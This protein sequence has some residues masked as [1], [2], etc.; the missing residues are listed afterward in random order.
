MEAGDRR[1][2]ESG[3]R[4]DG[5]GSPLATPSETANA[6]TE[7]ALVRLADAM[8]RLEAAVERRRVADSGMADVAD[9]VQRLNEDRA[10]L[11]RRLD[12]AEARAARRAEAQRVVSGRLVKAMELVRAVLDGRVRSS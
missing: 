3:G 9:I 8:K 6:A 11:A 7:D 4:A 2:A 12:A 10:E 5:A 1:Q